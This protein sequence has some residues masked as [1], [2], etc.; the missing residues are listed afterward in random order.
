MRRGAPPQIVEDDAAEVGTCSV[1]ELIAALSEQSKT[2]AVLDVRSGDELVKGKIPTARHVPSEALLDGEAGTKQAHTLI[3]DFA[4]ENVEKLIV[5]CM[6]S[7]GRGPAVVQ[8]LAACGKEDGAPL[9]ILLLEGGFHKYL[10][11]VYTMNGGG[12]VG[13]VPALL[14][15]VDA[16]AW[17]LTATHG[18]VESAAVEA[19]ETLGKDSL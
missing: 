2:T 1:E 5:H 17:R 16:N 13:D 8:L 11:Q 10:N 7:M 3:A 9:E 15:K 6:Y 12:T 4:K 18:L 14:E 19:M